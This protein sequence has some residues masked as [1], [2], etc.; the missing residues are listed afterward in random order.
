MSE[1]AA[2]AM[3]ARFVSGS[4]MRHVAVMTFTGALGLM[5][6]FLVDLLDLYLSEPLGAHRGD[7]GHRLCRNHRLRQS[8]DVDR[9]R[10]RGGGAGG[11][12][13]RGA[14]DRAGAQ[15]VANAAFNNLGRPNLSTWFN[16]GKATLGTIPFAWYGAGLGRLRPCVGG[17]GL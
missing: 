8:V 3:P 7:G 15:F 14:R 11:A 13:P 16:W 4:T 10:H 1:A 9:H 6:M 12:Q 2:P 5:A 17:G